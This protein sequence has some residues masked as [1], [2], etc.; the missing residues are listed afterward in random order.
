M[1]LAR[2]TTHPRGAGEEAPSRR[3]FLRGSAAVTGGFLGVQAFGRPA[4]ALQGAPTTPGQLVVLFLRGGQDHLSTVVPY[5]DTNYYSMR[6]DIAIGAGD[7]L[8]LDGTYGLH[9]VMSG[10]HSLY[11]AN[12]LAVVAGAGNPAANRSHFIAQDLWEFGS[13]LPPTDGMGWL[14]RYLTTTQTSGD[15]LFRG[16]TAGNNVNLSLRG[17][18]ALGIPGIDFFGLGGVS[19]F[20]ALRDN[21]V[22]GLYYGTTPLEKVGT[23]AL[24]GAADVAALN[25]STNPD[26]TGAAFEDIAELLDTNL[27]V[28]VITYNMGGWDT[29]NQMGTAANGNMRDLLGGLDTALS[30]FQ[31]DL[32][33]RGK[34][35]VTT[36]VMTEFGRR[37]FQNGSMGTDHGFGSVMLVMG[38][39]ANG[40]QVYGS[41]PPLTVANIE[42]TFDVPMTV[43]FR[44]VLGDVVRDVLD[45][46]DP[47]T[48]FPGHNYQSLGV[49]S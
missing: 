47:T 14:A 2:T 36:V 9:P 4:L 45:V 22:R 21:L 41:I 15:L 29:H 17:Y 48:V 20:A 43:D 40:G 39:A 7:V 44:D 13:D 32:D 8:D 19:G 24:D 3:S 31:A 30:N 27:G 12:R 6:P 37:A 38:G 16:V 25:G 10:L 23:D 11:Q 1:T 28:E 35:D 33:A 34:T 18:P 49:T 26:P 5:T 46:S 42:P